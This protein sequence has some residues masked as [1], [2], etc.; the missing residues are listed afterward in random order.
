MKYFKSHAQWCKS[1]EYPNHIWSW[2][3]RVLY[4]KSA[5]M[6]HKIYIF[7]K[8]INKI[9]FWEMSY[10]LNC[11][12]TIGIQNFTPNIKGIIGSDFLSMIY[13]N[14]VSFRKRRWTILN[15]SAWKSSLWSSQLQL[16][17]LTNQLFVYWFPKRKNLLCR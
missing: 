11:L 8:T 2:L 14:K 13:E 3:L 16:K 7:R 10:L 15:S 17:F 4:A 6:L 5:H 9:N 1:L 12:G